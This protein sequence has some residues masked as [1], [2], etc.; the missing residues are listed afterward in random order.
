[1]RPC[2]ACGTPTPHSRCEPCAAARAADLERRRQRPSTS[3]R[4][5]GTRWQRLSRRARVL[6]PWCSRCGT[7]VDLTADHVD[8]LAAGGTRTPRVDDGSIDVL[9]RR[10][11]ASKGRGNTRDDLTPDPHPEAMFGTHFGSAGGD[12]A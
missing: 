4:G 7:T 8:A 10:C 1:M 12:A 2:L 11:N 5:Y 9:C 6:Q 3:R